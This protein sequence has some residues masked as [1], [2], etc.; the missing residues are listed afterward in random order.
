M[1][2]R[3]TQFKDMFS[4]HGSIDTVILYILTVDKLYHKVT[5]ATYIHLSHEYYHIIVGYF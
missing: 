1:Y 4:K 2:L 3:S 5:L